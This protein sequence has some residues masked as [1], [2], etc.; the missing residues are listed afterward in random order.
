MAEAARVLAAAGEGVSVAVH[1]KE[2]SQQEGEL[3]S[4]AGAAEWAVEAGPMGNE[5]PPDATASAASSVG[6]REWSAAV[7]KARLTAGEK[8]SRRSRS[9]SVTRRLGV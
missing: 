5:Q 6:E 4:V 2:P 9:S 8:Q 3:D 7:L 1:L